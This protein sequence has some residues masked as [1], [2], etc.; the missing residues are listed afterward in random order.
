MSPFADL[1]PPRHRLRFEELPRGFVAFPARL[2]ELVAKE[3]AKF[4]EGLYT[5]EHE[6]ECLERSTLLG[7]YEGLPV[8]YRPAEGGIE[9]LAVGWQETLPYLEDPTVKVVQP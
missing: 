9:V 5:P 8:A 3:K 4:P 2:K 1:T 6:R 7:Y